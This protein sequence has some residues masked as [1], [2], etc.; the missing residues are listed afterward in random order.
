MALSTVCR[1]EKSCTNKTSV[2]NFQFIINTKPYQFTSYFCEKKDEDK[3]F[4]EARYIRNTG[5]RFQ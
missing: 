5:Q 3:F 2:E 4:F 1:A